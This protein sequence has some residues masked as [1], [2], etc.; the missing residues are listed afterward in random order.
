MIRV[1]DKTPLPKVDQ[2]L[3]VCGIIFYE[4]FVQ[5]LLRKVANKTDR[6][7]DIQTD[8]QTD[9]QMADIT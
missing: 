5:Q 2:F 7:T 3:S 1:L 4:S 8:R 9:R 6:Q